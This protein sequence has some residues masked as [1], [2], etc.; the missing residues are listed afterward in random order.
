VVTRPGR[1]SQVLA[2]I[3]D[4]NRENAYVGGQHTVY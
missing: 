4:L 1:T 2:E 3:R